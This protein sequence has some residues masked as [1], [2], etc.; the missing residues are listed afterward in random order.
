MSHP[1]DQFGT[2]A[3]VS[4]PNAVSGSAGGQATFLIDETT[5]LPLPDFE[6]RLQT[7]AIPAQVIARITTDPRLPPFNVP[8]YWNGGGLQ[9]TSVVH[10]GTIVYDD[11]GRSDHPQTVRM[12]TN[13]LPAI[14]DFGGTIQGGRFTAQCIVNWRNPQNGQTGS[15]PP[16]TSDYSIRGDNPTKAAIKALLPDLRA[17]VLAYM[18]SRF[19]Q[20]DNTSLPLFGPPHGFGTMQLDT[21]PATA[22][23]IWDWRDNIAGGLALYNKK[24]TEVSNH[25]TNI[26]KANPAAPHLTDEQM[27]LAL[28]QYYNGGFYWDWDAAAKVWK[29]IG[30]TAYGDNG[31]KIEKLVKAGTPPSDWN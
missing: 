2:T 14:F 24:K 8:W 1:L 26:Y 18:E 16:G 29:K 30:V 31:L 22:R 4:E 3:P 20:F 17:Q 25:F 9:I 27:S 12:T 6:G 15:T 21:P 28:Y 5:G 10:T 19:R 13:S 7:A 11:H 23:Q